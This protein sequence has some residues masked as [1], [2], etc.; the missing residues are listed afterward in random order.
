MVSS[1]LWVSVVLISC[2]ACLA[3]GVSAAGAATFTVTTTADSFDG[4][5][6]AVKCSLRDAVQAA[7]ADG[8][9]RARGSVSCSWGRHRRGRRTADSSQQRNPGQHRATIGSGG[10]IAL[11]ESDATL[12][13]TNVTVA[14]N[15]ASETDGG[16]FYNHET[17]AELA[18][19]TVIENEAMT[20]N[21]AFNRNDQQRVR[22]SIISRNKAPSGPDCEK[23]GGGVSLGGN[24][25]AASCGFAA[26]LDFPTADPLLAPLAGANVPVAEPLPGSPA[27]DHGLA[28]CPATDA[29]G[30]ARP[31]GGAC[32][33]GAAE[34]PVQVG[35]PAPGG[36]ITGVSVSRTRFRAGPKVI[37]NPGKG[38]TPIG[39]TIS[40][41]LSAAAKVK[42]TVLRVARGRRAGG[43]CLAPT[44]ARK[45]KPRCTRLIRAGSLP[46]ASF[47]AGRDK[48]N[49]SGRVAGHNLAPGRYL[50]QLAVP[51]SGT[52]AKTPVLRIVAR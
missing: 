5:C 6:T 12:S 27:I 34:R 15:R 46:T 9:P 33:S 37:A 21:G 52:V 11:V 48:I 26:P 40:F 47:S 42:P 13:L 44:K 25:G 49:F 35:P 43:K 14:G 18:Y 41:R 32:D 8:K 4:A 10:G 36:K 50:V 23:G 28:P 1:R 38:K 19:T 20:S 17:A 31:Q 3:L 45:D 24:V 16:I 30:V 2:C 39:T 7:N 29:R 51:A 22:S